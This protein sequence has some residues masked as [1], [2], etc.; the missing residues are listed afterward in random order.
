MKKVFNN[1]L[2]GH[3][4]TAVG[5]FII[6]LFCFQT[7]QANSTPIKSNKKNF[8]IKRPLNLFN[9]EESVDTIFNLVQKVGA[10]PVANIRKTRLNKNEKLSKAKVS[11]KSEK[12]D[13]LRQTN[14]GKFQST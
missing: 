11:I 14:A 4:L 9:L 6:L 2:L 8:P 7:Y 1:S 13:F 12:Q 5:S 10:K 3:F